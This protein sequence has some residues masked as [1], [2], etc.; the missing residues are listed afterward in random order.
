MEKENQKSLSCRNVFIRHLR[1]FVSDGMVNEREKIRRS[2]ITNF[3]DD[4]SLCYNGK[5]FTLIELLV[6]VLIIGILA[7]VAVPQYEKAIWKSRGAQLSTLAKNLSMAQETY[8]MA[9]GDYA[10]SFGELDLGFDNLDPQETSVLELS[11]PSTDAI[12]GN[13]MF[14]LA[15]NA[16]S[17]SSSN[18]VLSMAQF[19]TGP[20]KDAGYVFVHR[21]VNFPNLEG[22]FLCFEKGHLNGKFCTKVMGITTTPLYTGTSRYY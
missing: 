6:V 4:K 7:A 11:V 19:K 9:N 12:R 10:K 15:I 22:K 8:F 14:E 20:Y 21:H 17:N 16:L 3:R 5:A 2:R 18:F 1:I 13:D